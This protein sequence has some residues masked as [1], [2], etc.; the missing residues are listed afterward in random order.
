MTGTIAGGRKARLTNYAKYGPDFYKRIGSKGGQN[1]HTGGFAS[2]ERDKNGLTGPERAKIYGTKGGRISRR[3]K[4]SRKEKQ[5]I[6][7]PGEKL[8]NPCNSTEL[9]PLGDEE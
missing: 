5:Y 4:E 7:R 8:L 2:E 9:E 3:G 6:W 1:G